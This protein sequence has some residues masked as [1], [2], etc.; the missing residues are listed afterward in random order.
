VRSRWTILAALFGLYFAPGAA[1]L[2]RRA[3][4]RRFGDKSA[5][6]AALLMMLAGELLM[7]ASMSWS[8]QVA[9]RLVAGSGGV[10]MNVLMT[11]ARPNDAP[12]RDGHLLHGVLRRHV[13]GPAIGGRVSTTAG[14]AS[15][16]LVRL[17]GSAQIGAI[18]RRVPHAARP[19]RHR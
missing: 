10:L 15:A 18:H 12:D 2:A 13:V 16:T 5:V 19:G 8:A 9:G 4:G 7:A 17:G 14:A 11:R 1:R 3:I 6:L